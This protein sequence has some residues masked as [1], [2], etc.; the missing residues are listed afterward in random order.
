MYVCMYGAN[1][2]GNFLKNAIFKVAQIFFL[3]YLGK[4]F[5]AVNSYYQGQLTCQF[6]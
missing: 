3:L 6:L 4:D 2:R 5:W 1:F